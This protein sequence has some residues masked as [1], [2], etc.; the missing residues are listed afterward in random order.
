M[1]L[2]L[3]W[4][5]ALLL[6][7]PALAV[8][9]DEMLADQHLE[10]RARAVSQQL[11]C[12]VCQNQTIDDSDA[13]LARDLRLLVRERL[14]RGDS[15]EQA[16]AYIVARYGHYVLLQPPFEAATLL[17][18]LGPAA[19]IGLGGA[20]VSLYLKSRRTVAADAPLSPEDS[21]RVDALLRQG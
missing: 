13:P 20:G 17:L 3:S 18:W 21:A 19:F 6:A 11:R 1:R 5:A 7:V 16:V 2:L 12:M 4:L 14:V 10:A 8:L 15:D 9:P